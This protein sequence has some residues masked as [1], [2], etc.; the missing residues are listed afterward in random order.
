MA[1][2]VSAALALSKL[3]GNLLPYRHKQTSQRYMRAA[4]AA[5]AAV[6]TAVVMTVGAVSTASPIPPINFRPTIT[7]LSAHDRLVHIKGA[8]R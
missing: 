2:L 5:A 3:R 6:R 4:P 8:C 7:N 1:L